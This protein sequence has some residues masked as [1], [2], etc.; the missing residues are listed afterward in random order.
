MTILYGLNGSGKTTILNIINSISCGSVEELKRYKFSYIECHFIDKNND[1]N[2]VNV[3]K[4]NN[5]FRVLIN[6]EVVYLSKVEDTKKSLNYYREEYAEIDTNKQRMKRDRDLFWELSD[7]IYLSIDRR[8]SGNGLGFR[9][10]RNRRIHSNNRSSETTNIDQ[11]IKLAQAYFKDH[12]YFVKETSTAIQSQIE[13]SMLEEISLPVY[14]SF[15]ELNDFDLSKLCEDYKKSFENKEI[16]NNIKKLVDQ[17]IDLKGKGIEDSRFYYTLLQLNKLNNVMLKISSQKN[18]L[19]NL[20][21]IETD[22]LDEINSY[23]I[24]TNK[25]IKYSKSTLSFEDVLYFTNKEDIR[26]EALSLNYLSSGEK[27]LIILLIFSMLNID[28]NN[29][30]KIF[31]VD[32]PELSLHIA[33]QKRLVSTILKYSKNTQIII[34]TH[35]PDIINNYYDFVEEV[36]GEA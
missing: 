29:G 23:F 10:S 8:V 18:Y 19:D 6:G 21:K 26:K 22:F 11:S 33:W 12:R 20:E 17:Y 32:E 35:S 28:S 25:S 7:T 3:F 14:Q 9:S 13:R 5:E 4:D 30:F 27:Q 36:R 31:M 2:I 15:K 24:D 34:A 1:S 16:Y